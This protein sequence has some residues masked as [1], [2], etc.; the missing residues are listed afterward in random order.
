[1]DIYTIVLSQAT[2]IHYANRYVR[3]ITACVKKNQQ[4]N[5]IGYTENH[6]ILPVNRYP[7]FQNFNHHPWNC[8]VLTYRQHILAHWL[9]WKVF[10]DHAHAK[11]FR[12]MC[13]MEDKIP[14]RANTYTYQR[15]REISQDRSEFEGYCVYQDA[16]GNSHWL[17]TDDPRVLS[18]EVKHHQTGMGYYRDIDG[19]TLWLPTNHPDVVSGKYPCILKGVP[20]SEEGRQN[21][22]RGIHET[23]F[24]AKN[25][26][27][28]ENLGRIPKSDP[29]WESGEIISL[30]T[31]EAVYKDSNGNTMRVRTDDPRVL[32]GELI[33]VNSGKMPARDSDGNTFYVDVDDPRVLDGTLV[34]TAKGFGVYQNSSGEIKKLPVDDPRVLSGEYYS[35]AKGKS[36]YID[37][38]GKSHYVFVDDPR[39]LDGTLIS[40]AS[41][42]T[43]YIDSNG[44]RIYT[45]TDDPRVLSGELVG[46]TA[47]FAPYKNADGDR[48]FLHK[49][50][51]RVLSGEYFGINKGRVMSDEEKARRKSQ[52]IASGRQAKL[53]CDGTPIG[54]I[55][56]DD[57][58][59][60]TGEIV[61]LRKN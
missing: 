7:E 33:S 12:M 11:A 61:S 60:S 28:G 19:T 41:N 53:S 29:R 36:T 37:S 8:A 55:R 56:L 24:P 15:A 27:T 6:H 48:A 40:I 38:N 49:D 9:L 21:I 34:S 32:S 50:D 42:K 5:D 57:P 20:K 1:M 14:S 54:K 30:G 16:N 3:Y 10:D 2:N 39:V 18:G 52:R 31:D 58:R 35:I 13:N 51:P 59:W 23:G 26:V 44:N 45:T 4:V 47:G 46:H 25:A 43:H 22:I 17:R